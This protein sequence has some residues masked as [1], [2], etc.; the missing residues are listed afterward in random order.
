MLKVGLTGGI[1]SG[2]T[3]VAEMFRARGC[4]VLNAD[5]IAH[6][7][8]Q[9]GQPAYDEIVRA[10]GTEVVGPDGAIERRRLGQRVFAD[11]KGLERLNQI[12]HPQVGAARDAEFARLAAKDPAGIVLLEAALLIEAGYHRQLDKLVVT[13]CRPE[14]QV[15]RLLKNAEL[16]RAEAEQRVAAQLPQEEKRRQADYEI[17]CSGSLQATE[18]QVE[19]VL[20]ELRRL[21]DAA[22]P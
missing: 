17:D 22:R 4:R 18:E 3:T 14:Q 2:K 10:F 19:K 16:T 21:A 7:L 12:G 11:R 8:I 6:N 20:A 13:W 5:Q 1:A 9:P 15:E